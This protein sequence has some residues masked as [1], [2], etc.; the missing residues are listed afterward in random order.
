[1]IYDIKNTLLLGEISIGTTRISV[2]YMFTD[3]YY[4][5]K[6]ILSSFTKKNI[7]ISLHFVEHS[8][9]FCV[10]DNITFAS[11]KKICFQTNIIKKHHE[12]LILT[13]QGLLL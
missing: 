2:K 5:I 4:Y 6:N 7:T 13:L 3:I 1:M 9:S 10:Y 12:M 11:K 8:S